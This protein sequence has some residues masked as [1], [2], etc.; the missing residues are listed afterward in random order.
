MDGSGKPATDLVGSVLESMTFTI[1]NGKLMR[2]T[3]LSTQAAKAISQQQHERLMPACAL[4]AMP[5][6][7]MDAIR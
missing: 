2:V 1:H 7:L 5:L 3:G 4:H 6:W